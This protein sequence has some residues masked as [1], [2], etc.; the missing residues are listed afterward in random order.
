MKYST[1]FLRIFVLDCVSAV[2]CMCVWAYMSNSGLARPN[3]YHVLD[4]TM[5]VLSS[6]GSTLMCTSLPRTTAALLQDILELIV[7]SAMSTLIQWEARDGREWSLLRSLPLGCEVVQPKFRMQSSDWVLCLCLG[8]SMQKSEVHE[9]HHRTIPP[10]W[11]MKRAK[12][13]FVKHCEESRSKITHSLLYLLQ[14]TD[15][16]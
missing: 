4:P 15:P 10:T 7:V 12:V 9:F 8:H 2:H 5:R 14:P 3:P 1:F 13:A 6:A 16:S 11:H